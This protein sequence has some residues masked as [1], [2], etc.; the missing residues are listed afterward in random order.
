MCK[1]RQKNAFIGKPTDIIKPLWN[2]RQGLLRPHRREFQ[3]LPLR[4]KLC[5]TLTKGRLM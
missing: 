4:V 3:Q 5:L 2:L 1:V